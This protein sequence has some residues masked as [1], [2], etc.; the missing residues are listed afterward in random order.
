MTKL[1]KII[2]IFENAN[3]EGLCEPEYN[4]MMEWLNNLDESRFTNDGGTI[5]NLL[6]EET[7]NGTI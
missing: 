5:F 4:E 7:I 3:I 1:E 2:Y 6:N